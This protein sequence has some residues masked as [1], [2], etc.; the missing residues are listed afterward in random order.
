MNAKELRFVRHAGQSVQIFRE[1]I[2]QKLG[3]FLDLGGIE[4]FA[5]LKPLAR[6]VGFQLAKK[7]VR[8]ID[9]LRKTHPTPAALLPL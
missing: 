5:V 4:I 6:V 2:S 7:P 9:Q 8:L 3:W 1:E